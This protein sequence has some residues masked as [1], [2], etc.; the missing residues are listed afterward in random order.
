L[1][2]LGS[3]VSDTVPGGAV[4]MLPLAR[5]APASATPRPDKL[6]RAIPEGVYAKWRWWSA[7]SVLLQR[8]YAYRK[9]AHT[10]IIGSNLIQ[11]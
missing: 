10:A 1:T 4:E 8:F 5:Y 6:V 9:K 2:I 3:F 11:E 7:V